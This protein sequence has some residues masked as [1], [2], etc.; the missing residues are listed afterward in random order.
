MALG[1]PEKG[2]LLKA[3]TELSHEDVIRN[4]DE[5]SFSR[6]IEADARLKGVEEREGARR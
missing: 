5:G 6:V 4:L 2:K 1:P 3:P